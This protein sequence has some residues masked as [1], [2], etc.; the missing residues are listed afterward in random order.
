[1]RTVDIRR[2]FLNFFTDRD[3][4]VVPS[5]SLVTDDPTMLFTT[6][7]M[8]QFKPYFLRLSTPPATRLTS[9]QKCVRT[10]DIEGIGH[11]D[12]HTTFFEMLGNFS[13]GSYGPD[14][15]V[16]WAYEFLTERLGLDPGRLWATVYRDDDETPAR[17]Q[18]IG[19][20]P[21]RIQRLGMADNYWSTGGPGPCG[22][23]TEIFYDRGPEFG[24]DGGPAA[25]PDRF[26]EV[27]N[28]VFMRHVRGEGGTDDDFPIVGDL[29]QACVESGL[30]VERAAVVL[31]DVPHIHR[32]DAL[33]PVLSSVLGQASG[34]RTRS[35]ELSARIVV[36]HVRAASFLLADGVLPGPDGRGYVLRRLVRRAVRHAR[37]LGVESPV[38]ADL[39]DQ[40]VDTHMESWPELSGHRALVRQ[41][42]AHEE[43][44]FG[45][46]LTH[47]TRLLDTAI[48]RA[49]AESGT[50]EPSG[51]SGSLEPARTAGSSGR[52][53]ALSGRTA[54]ELHDTY[55]FPVDL[56]VEV[57]AEAGL[58]VDTDRF[59]ALMEHQ[60]ERARQARTS[61]SGDVDVP[62]R[63]L[64]ERHGPTRFVGYD[65]HQADGT[66]LAL[67]RDGR[68]LAVATEGERCT[69]VLDR[70]PM[71]AES[72]GQ[73]GDTGTIRVASGSGSPGPDGDT[74]LRVLDT[75]RGPGGLHVHE[76]E[77][78]HGEL[79]PG[80]PAQSTVDV[81]RRQ[82]T[83]RSHSATHVLH[84]VLREHLGGHARQQGSL[85]A[86]GRLRFDV[87]HFAPL[88]PDQVR[89]VEDGVNQRLLADPEVRVWETSQAEARAAGA[90][91]LFG[92]TYGEVVRVVDIGDFSR[93][94]CGGTHVGHASAAGPVRI[95]GES[96]VGAGVR[97]LEALT[98]VD[99][100]R[101]ADHEHRLLEQIQDLLGG[102]GGSGRSGSGASGDRI[103]DQ[104]R[105][106]LTDLADAE[107][108]LGKRRRA[109]LLAGADRLVSRRRDTASGGWLVASRVDE[110]GG[111]D[112]GGVDSRDVDLR[113]LAQAV[114]ER[115]PRD[116]PG[117]VV[118]ARAYDGR[119]QLVLAVDPSS[120][121]R[122]TAKELL[123]PAGR[124]IGGGAGGNGSF[125]HAGGRDVERLDTALALAADRLT[126]HLDA[127]AGA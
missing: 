53:P 103:L 32:T 18:R 77:V 76:V 86:P 41:A 118:L 127:T 123:T 6:A 36:D 74:S 39:A 44:A 56:T 101:Y 85:V 109:D 90:I 33:L 63:A 3:H 84:A 21:E 5:S 37:L 52:R 57:A 9:A 126:E 46:T 8:V 67:V 104:L 112:A 124:A 51:P 64:A 4:Q 29:P 13:F 60:R 42:I 92:E 23:C 117:G 125:A 47:G 93:E 11:T 89:A 83:A 62:Y 28:L 116:R 19:I 114:L 98:G 119:A 79:R 65:R 54:F 97:R 81:R 38:L 7:G 110:P 106:R 82:A 100:L 43:E 25:D 24:R 105:R 69:L 66:V 40:V 115:G 87:S 113:E 68:E 75:R 35:P 27:W 61:A 122:G 59:A 108:E 111:V 99:A 10:V 50:P 15:V 107:R 34:S 31:Q 70:T 72:G 73:V 80:E 22:P 12:R 91:A 55:G 45:R 120:A 88:D 16:P 20:P 71:Y 1:M 17:W 48:R 78:V 94:L 95:V 14:E 26:L 121:G 58:T 102:S 49:R 96:S 30:G 2:T